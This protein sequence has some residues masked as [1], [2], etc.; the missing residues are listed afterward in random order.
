LGLDA[1]VGLAVVSI[2][3]DVVAFHVVPLP[4]DG[5]IG[6]AVVLVTALSIVYLLAR[7]AV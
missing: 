1:G 7:G 3:D 4:F 5:V 2:V 6:T